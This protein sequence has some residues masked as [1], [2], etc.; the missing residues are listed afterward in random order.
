MSSTRLVQPGEGTEI[1][2]EF[3]TNVQDPKL[4]TE[5]HETYRQQIA[6]TEAEEGKLKEA[7]SLIDE[8]QKTLEALKSENAKHDINKAEI[9][10]EKDILASDRNNITQLLFAKEE[11]IK[12]DRQEHDALVLLQTEQHNSDIEELE[13]Q[14]KAFA[15][16]MACQVQ[17]LKTDRDN[18]LAELEKFE[19]IIKPEIEKEK[20]RI[21]DI[22]QKA[23][24]VKVKYEKKLAL[25]QSDIGDD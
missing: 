22:E 2:K 20:L 1:L 25:I 23:L 5:A 13:R 15:N 11:Q 4:I 14:K 17:S 21:A 12:K 24:A 10:K 8:H 18:H 16:D 3:L 6:L 9:E 19:T 7:R